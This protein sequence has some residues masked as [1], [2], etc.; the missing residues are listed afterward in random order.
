MGQACYAAH[1]FATQQFSYFKA[2]HAAGIVHKAPQ[3]CWVWQGPQPPRCGDV[4]YQALF[5]AQHLLQT[6]KRPTQ[7][8][9]QLFAEPEQLIPAFITIIFCS[10]DAALEA[11]SY[12][13]T[14]KGCCW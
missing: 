8:P 9:D 7:H 3:I 13:R 1:H 11:S 10:G 6:H 14:S 4:I 5:S 12:C 2:I